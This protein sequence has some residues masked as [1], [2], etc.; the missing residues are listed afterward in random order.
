M[1]RWDLGYLGTYSQDRQPVLESLLL[2]PARR[3]PR[4]RFVVAGAQ[5]PP[6]LRWPANVEH[7]AH[8]A[9]AQHATFYSS[10]RWALNVTRADMV[11]AGHSP[12]VRL[13]EAA[14]S[15]AP[16]ISDRWPGLQELFQP[17]DEIVV[18]ASPDDVLRA[19][20]LPDSQRNR[21]AAIGRRRVLA[22]HTSQ[23][24]AAEVESYLRAAIQHRGTRHGEALSLPLQ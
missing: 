2:E 16:I 22:Q 9:P 21:I 10:L 23:Q 20:A 3:L 1:T 4:Q 15:G 11:K 19:L 7:I 8:V 13:F 6:H 17:D 24:R 14:A 12:S 18:A 5:Y